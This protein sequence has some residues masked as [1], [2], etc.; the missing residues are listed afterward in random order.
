MNYFEKYQKYKIKYL[1][2][3]QFGGNI[4]ITKSTKSNNTVKINFKSKVIDERFKK[5]IEDKLMEIGLKNFFW[6]DNICS[7]NYPSHFIVSNF[8][9]D[10]IFELIIELFPRDVVKKDLIADIEPKTSDTISVSSRHPTK[11]S[12]ELSR[13]IKP[14]KYDE[15]WSFVNSKMLYVALIVSPDTQVGKAI[16]DRFDYMNKHNGY[17][18]KSIYNKFRGVYNPD[19]ITDPH[20]TLF[21]ISIPEGKEIDK[22]ILSN[23]GAMIKII[24]KNYIDYINNKKKMLYSAYDNYDILGIL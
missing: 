23:F 8:N 3:K 4:T 19:I 11:P 12:S 20:L 18:I 6:R 1:E 10:K 2:L 21:N 7:A 24:M 17:E 16:K 14:T 15:P 9:L 13:A 22:F 5:T